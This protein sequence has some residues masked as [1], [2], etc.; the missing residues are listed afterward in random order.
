MRVTIR[1]PIDGSAFTCSDDVADKF[2][3][4]S[5]RHGM[6]IWDIHK[7]VRVVLLGIE[8]WDDEWYPEREFD[9]LKCDN[10]DLRHWGGLLGVKQLLAIRDRARRAILRR[11]ERETDPI[12][13]QQLEAMLQ[14]KPEWEEIQRRARAMMAKQRRTRR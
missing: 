8:G 7:M 10:Y 3:D 13:K 5:K 1:D 4:L 14:P 6:P 9:Q 2:V 12:K 11:A